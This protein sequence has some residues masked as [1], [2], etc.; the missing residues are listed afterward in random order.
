MELLNK[1]KMVDKLPNTSQKASFFWGMG[2][3]EFDN[4]ES[5]LDAQE[6]RVFRR[7]YQGFRNISQDRLQYE[8]DSYA[9]EVAYLVRSIEP[10]TKILDAGCGL[11]SDSILCGILGADATGVDLSEERLAVANKR[12]SFY[13]SKLGRSINTK[14][15]AKS[16]F[17]FAENYDIIWSRQSISHVDPAAKFVEFAYSHLNKEGKLIINDSN[18]LN[19]YVYIQAKRE[20]WRSGGIHTTKKNPKTGEAVSY[21]R[22]RMFTVLSIED[23]LRRSGFQIDAVDVRGFCPYLSFPHYKSKGISY[24]LNSIFHRIPGIRMFGGTYTVVGVKR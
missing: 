23:I 18:G 22:E 21:A 9:Q 1:L 15:L 11:G 4:C 2:K 13:E 17:D 12:F 8:K 14:F 20:H 3:E 7:Y 5:F 16:V 10:G 6:C 19:P 24:Y